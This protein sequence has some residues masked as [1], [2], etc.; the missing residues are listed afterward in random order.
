[1]SACRASRILPFLT[2]A[3]DTRASERF[4]L[5]SLSHDALRHYCFRHDGRQLTPAAELGISAYFDDD[6]AMTCQEISPMMLSFAGPIGQT[7]QYPD[8]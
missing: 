3:G 1:M 8:P 7:R 5:L 4:A 6:A 2:A